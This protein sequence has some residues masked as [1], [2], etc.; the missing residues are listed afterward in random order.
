MKIKI[1]DF[2]QFGAQATKEVNDERIQ[3]GAPDGNFKGEKTKADQE[4]SSKFSPY[5]HFSGH[6]YS[7]VKLDSPHLVCHIHRCAAPYVP[8]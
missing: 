6:K 3:I 1:T 2:L 5:V 4:H 7:T 8:L